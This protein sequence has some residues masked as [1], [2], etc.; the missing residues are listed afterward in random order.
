MNIIEALKQDLPM[1]RPLPK[2]AG[3]NGDGYLSAHFVK[4]YLLAGL[5]LSGLHVS[6]NSRPSYALDEDD[7]LANDWE[8][9]TDWR[10][11]AEIIA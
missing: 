8:V 6:V 11:E 5:Y 2:F 7:L 1:R 10:T 9:H 4:K 3:S